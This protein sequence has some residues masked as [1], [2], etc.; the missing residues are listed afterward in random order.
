MVINTSCEPRQP[1]R[2]HLVVTDVGVVFIETRGAGKC[3]QN[4]MQEAPQPAAAAGIEKVDVT[5]MFHL[6]L[7]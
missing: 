2:K 7:E 1:I 6:Q 4:A 5:D 3:L